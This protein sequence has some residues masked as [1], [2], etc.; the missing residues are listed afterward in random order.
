MR[1]AALDGW[2]FTDHAL[3]R[4]LK[5]RLDPDEIREALNTPRC[6]IITGKG[7]EERE[8]ATCTVVVDPTTRIIITVY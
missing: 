2:R 8:S 6:R 5:R 4:A 3:S 7:T 1:N